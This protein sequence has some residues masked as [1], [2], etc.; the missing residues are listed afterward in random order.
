MVRK[1]LAAANNFSYPNIYTVW[2]S[3]QISDATFPF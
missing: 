2:Y 1:W 3:A